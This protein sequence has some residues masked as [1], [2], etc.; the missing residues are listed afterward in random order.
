[1][2]RSSRRVLGRLAPLLLGGAAGL[3]A[4]TVVAITNGALTVATTQTNL[5]ALVAGGT[6]TKPMWDEVRAGGVEGPLPDREAHVAG[7]L[8][9]FTVRHLRAGPNVVTVFALDTS[10]LAPPG[11]WEPEPTPPAGSGG[12]LRVTVP[13]SARGQRFFRLQSP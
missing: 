6:V 4:A 2:A 11:F 7:S 10:N 13:I 5:T 12:M 1:M 9:P 3:P 8:W